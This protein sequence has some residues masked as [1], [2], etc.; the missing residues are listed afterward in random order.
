MR[1]DG[2]S[3]RRGKNIS[4]EPTDLKIRLADERT[5][6]DEDLAYLDGLGNAGIEAD[7]ALVIEGE[8]SFESGIAGARRLLPAAYL[9]A[10]GVPGAAGAI[11]VLA[12]LGAFYAATDGVLAALVSRLVAPQ[13]RGS[14]IAA[15]QTVVALARFAS[16]VGFGSLWLVLGPREAMVVMAALVALALPVAFR[17]IRDVDRRS[18]VEPPD[19]RPPQDDAVVPA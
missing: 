7:P 15:A 3:N 13:A 1:A 12:L 8:F 17:L 18:G 9:V 11:V 2:L 4:S 19:G 14:G 6:Q 16:S 5:G 10:A